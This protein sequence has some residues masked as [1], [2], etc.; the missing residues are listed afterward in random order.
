MKL[1]ACKWL[2]YAISD[3][4]RGDNLYTPYYDVLHDF[5]QHMQH[6]A[7]LCR[8]M[9]LSG[10][11]L[12]VDIA[13]KMSACGTFV[14]VGIDENGEFKVINANFCRQRLCP[15]C[16][17]RRSLKMYA[18]M[19]SAVD[20]L[21]D[22]YRFLHLVLSRPNV[23]ASGLGYELQ[24]LYA[25]AGKLFRL[26]FVKAAVRGYLR[27][28]EVTYNEDSDDYHPHLHITLA[29][30]KSYFNSR[31]YIK[32]DRWVNAWNEA[33]NWDRD[34]FGY[35]L[36]LHVQRVDD[37]PKAVAELAK[38]S[39]KPIDLRSEHTGAALQQ[40]F[41]YATVLKGRRMMQT[42]GVMREQIADDKIKRLEVLSD[43]D[44]S[45]AKW[46]AAFEWSGE[47]YEQCAGSS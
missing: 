25:A 13:D 8:L 26:D 43:L 37:S 17:W 6:K 34:L 22:N 2:G 41:T 9:Y 30:P 21:G 35:D 39:T 18:Y 32:R 47:G 46:L 44:T 28:T 1:Y 15:V 29:V 16:Q 36:S 23:L 19:S 14:D 12:L 27:C 5:Q 20:A 10:E 31:I 42:S 3:I 45:A 11:R 7:A 38:Y 24:Q 4:L 33:N 40:L